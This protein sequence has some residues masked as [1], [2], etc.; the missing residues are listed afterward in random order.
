MT[1]AMRLTW[2]VS[3]AGDVLVCGVVTIKIRGSDWNALRSVPAA[4]FKHR[5]Q[6]GRNFP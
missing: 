4:I 2:S 5:M 3:L 1:L 6:L